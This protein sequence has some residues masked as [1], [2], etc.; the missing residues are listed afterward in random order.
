M[1][2]TRM[3]TGQ[4]AQALCERYAREL[5]GVAADYA[6]VFGCAYI[7]AEI[8]DDR[9]YAARRLEQN[10][11]RRRADFRVLLP[12]F[13]AYLR[14]HHPRVASTPITASAA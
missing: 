2:L 11:T 14:K 5:G 8:R 3:T 6:D 9:L 1:G 12:D 13:L 4:C 7:R 10:T